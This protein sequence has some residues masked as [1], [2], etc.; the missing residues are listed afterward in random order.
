MLQDFIAAITTSAG[1]AVV[2]G[3]LAA[4]EALERWSLNGSN[5]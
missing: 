1:E 4:G 2:V 5:A 3:D